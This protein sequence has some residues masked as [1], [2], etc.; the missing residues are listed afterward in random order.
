MTLQTPNTRS[1]PPWKRL[2]IT[3]AAAGVGF[4]LTI[5]A[6]V[7]CVLWYASRPEPW[8]ARAIRARYGSAIT[9]DVGCFVVGE[10][11]SE[12][13]ACEDS[14]GEVLLT[15]DIENTTNRDYR[16]AEQSGLTIME[17]HGNIL[18]A[19]LIT[20]GPDRGNSY[21]KIDTPIFVPAHQTV[22]VEVRGPYECPRCRAEKLN[23]F[24]KDNVPDLVLFDATSHYE[25]EFPRP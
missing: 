20:S 22:A 5:A 12:R 14:H 16:I 11:E 24:V 17:R 19:T 2:V 1:T 4:A 15:Y 10:S 6:I 9:N 23:S 7:G 25:I 13:N 18:E 3:S 21:W 8:N